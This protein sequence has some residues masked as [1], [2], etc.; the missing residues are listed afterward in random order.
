MWLHSMLGQKRVCEAT[1]FEK[2]NEMLIHTYKI[3]TIPTENQRF[4]KQPF[5][6]NIFDLLG[7]KK[8]ESNR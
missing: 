5:N 4:D 7:Q 8:L 6:V 1:D 3:F 2:E